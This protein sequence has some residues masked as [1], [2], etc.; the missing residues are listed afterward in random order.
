MLADHEDEK[1]KAVAAK[2]H[3]FH[4]LETMAI[5][6]G[7]FHRRLRGS[8]HSCAPAAGGRLLCTFKVPGYVAVRTITNTTKHVQLPSVVWYLEIPVPSLTDDMVGLSIVRTSM[9][10]GMAASIDSVSVSVSAATV[11]SSVGEV[12]AS[13]VFDIAYFSPV[14]VEVTSK[15]QA[16]LSIG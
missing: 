13:V 4:Q 11:V 2:K 15:L 10:T 12:R 3:P 8:W 1:D 14:K 7:W 9:G 6:E 5:R 16:S